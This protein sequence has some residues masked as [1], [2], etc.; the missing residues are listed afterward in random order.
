M[1]E[2]VRSYSANAGPTRK[3][4]KGCLRVRSLLALVLL[5]VIGYGFWTTR[6]THPAARLVPTGQKYLVAFTDLLNTRQRMAESSVW[7]AVP[8]GTALAAVPKALGQELELP[9]GLPGGVPEWILNNLFHEGLYLTGND[10]DA[11]SDALVVT[12]MSRVG[13]LLEWIHAFVPGIETDHA[14]GLDLRHIQD[15]DVYYAVRGRV[16]VLSRSRDALVRSLTLTSETAIAEETLLATVSGA[17]REDVRGTFALDKDDPLGTCFQH[18][19]FAIRLDASEAR[20]TCRVVLHPACQERWRALLN[21]A[22]S[23]PL[24]APPPG[25][26]SISA[27]F[28]K[29][30]E[31]CWAAIGEGL[32]NSRRDVWPDMPETVPAI[33]SEDQWREWQAVEEGVELGLGSFLTNIVGPLG[34]GFRVSWC[35]VDLN[36][37]M[38][39]PEL[40]GTFDGNPDAL[41]V[42]REALPPIP[43]DAPRWA[44]F[45]R[46][47]PELNTV[48][49]PMIGGPALEPT[50][51][52][53]GSGIL[54]S[55]SSRLAAALMESG[56][57]AGQLPEAGNLHIA[58]R[59]YPCVESVVEAGRLLVD[60]GVMRGHTP[61]TYA[62]MTDRWLVQAGA[63]EEASLHA[64]VDG[65]DIAL[66]VRV[67][68]PARR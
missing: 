17:G 55:T 15:P 30:V 62:A 29:P 32:T 48:T 38:P 8:E 47:E 36:E 12:K 10:L 31:A 23:G 64:A 41:D 51:A 66:D 2:A 18:V 24:M 44:S 61:K 3:G 54:V 57:V 42:F 60:Q 5:V 26:V 37:M 56:G 45:P 43:E 67:V 53:Y 49:L 6:D 50:A 19:G 28:G 27:N 63:V 59:P 65:G 13:K 39:M 22:T 34:P 4:R 14:G 40:A 58:V 21:G 46:F 52:P 35:A 25:M 11:F 9:A 20:A 68:C 33:F 7:D 1:S 16:L